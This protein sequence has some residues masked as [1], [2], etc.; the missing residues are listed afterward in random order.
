V[1][2]WVSDC[3]DDIEALIYFTDGYGDQSSI[4]APA[5]DTV[6]LTTDCT[7]FPFGEVIKFEEE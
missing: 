6:W 1:F 2:D 5:L 3:N 7:D 4:D